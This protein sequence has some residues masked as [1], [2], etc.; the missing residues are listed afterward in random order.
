MTFLEVIGLIISILVIL[1]CCFWLI[2]SK[3][4]RYLNTKK[5]C[6]VCL[7]N[8]ILL[9]D[10]MWVVN[11]EKAIMQLSK[12]A[13]KEPNKHMQKV[14]H[15][16]LQEDIVLHDFLCSRCKKQ[17]FTDELADDA[18]QIGVLFRIYPQYDNNNKNSN[19]TA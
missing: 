16:H 5:F 1:Y 19:Q 13:A 18:E 12:R 3:M 6:H 15:E 17:I 4:I 11:N 7:Q 9:E 10:A 14:L 8:G 2:S